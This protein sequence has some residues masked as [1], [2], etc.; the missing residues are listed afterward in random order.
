MTSNRP[1][2]GVVVQPY[3][4][5]GDPVL[6]YD[7]RLWS[8][9]DVMPQLGSFAGDGDLVVAATD[10]TA[11]EGHESYTRAERDGLSSNPVIADGITT[12][13]DEI[14]GGPEEL[15]FTFM[16]A[17]SA[18]VFFKHYI[19]PP[20][21]L[22]GGNW[23][24]GG[25]IG[26]F[27]ITPAG[28]G[29][30]LH[31]RSDQLTGESNRSYVLG[32]SDANPV[33]DI[34]MQSAASGVGASSLFGQNVMTTWTIDLVH[35]GGT[36]YKNTTGVVPLGN[37]GV[38]SAIRPGLGAGVSYRAAFGESIDVSVFLGGAFLFQPPKAAR[39]VSGLGL[40]EVG[41]PWPVV[42]FCMFRGEPTREELQP[43]YDYWFPPT[44][45]EHPPFA[46]R[47]IIG[48]S[49]N[50]SVQR[51]DPTARVP[52]S[53]P[54][55]Q[56]FTIPAGSTRAR[57][58]V[59]PSRAVNIA[60]YVRNVVFEINVT[61]GDEIEVIAGNRGS[62]APTEGASGGEPD[63][64]NGAVNTTTGLVGPSGSGSCRVYLNGE[65]VIVV[66]GCGAGA[67][68]S[69][70]TSWTGFYTDQQGGCLGWPTLSAPDGEGSLSGQ[71]LG[72]S[73]VA[74][75][76]GGIDPSLGIS[77]GSGS[78]LK[79]GDSIDAPAT[80][81]SNVGGPGGGGGRYGGGAGLRSGNFSSG[82]GGGGSTWFR[83]GTV[84]L[85]YMGGVR[86]DSV[87]SDGLPA[88]MNSSVVATY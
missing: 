47:V 6:M 36:L 31:I 55:S 39:P 74:G 25:G 45:I 32:N 8:G 85:L 41:D 18:S 15:P 73:Q 62:S 84:R 5:L 22:G 35:G 67:A 11:T 26:Q 12:T 1:H 43:W 40:D 49:L 79:G 48:G 33:D 28:T 51:I 54:P 80:G 4:P 17:V 66:G 70:G 34:D 72:A 2:A 44:V 52:S 23:G 65:L 88:E 78:F 63:G 56:T 37:G 24:T 57:V 59:T 9:A 64:G 14:G 20:A 81:A 30:L 69:N 7:T 27:F 13:W 29:G 60:N 19:N 83:P 46:N 87:S 86:F 77:A 50:T 10:P 61:E 16:W 71:G 82:G 38:G 68:T 3:A 75:G 21:I 53:T 42:G 58:A 76:P